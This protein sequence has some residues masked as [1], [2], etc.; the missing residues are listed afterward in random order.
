MLDL[1]TR[2]RIDNAR[3]ILVGKV[4]DPKSQVEQITIALIYKFMDD[5]D[6]EAEELGGRAT[7][8]KG[9]F[10]KYSWSNIFDP[11][12]GG[13]ELIN[14]YGEAITRM[15]QNKNIPQ[16]FRDIFKN[17]FLPYRDPETLKSFLK[18]INDFHYDHSERLG[19]AFEYLLS[20]LG[21][22][23]DAGSLRTPRHIIDFIVKVIAPKKN[24]TI[25]DPACGTAGF[26]ISAYKHIR[27]QNTDK[28][29]GNQLTP[30]D[31]KRLM[32][33]IVGHDISPDM[34]RLS[35][36]NMY[37]HGFQNPKI[38]EYD[39]LTSDERWNE[40]YDIILANPPFMTPKGGIRP[41]KRFSIQAN[42]S[43]VL[44]V[45]YI[46]EHIAT[47]GRAGVIVPEGIIFQSAN[48]Y[49]ALRKAL[50]ENG[51]LYAVVSLPAG[52]FNPYS[53]VK[54]SILLMD[55]TLAKKAKDILFVKIEN[56]GFDLGAQRRE[57]DRSDLTEALRIIQAYQDCVRK[58]KDFNV[59]VSD[60]G[61][62]PCACPDLMAGQ[63]QKGNH[64]GIAPTGKKISKAGE[65]TG[66]PL[67]K[68]FHIVPK[69]KIAESGDYNL[70]GD[71]YRERII[72]SHKDWPMVELAKICK[73]QYGYTATAQESGDF[74][75]IRITDIDN[76]GSLT[77]NGQKF[78]TAFSEANQYVLRKGDLL[79]ART[80][81]TFGKT[82]LFR[83][84]FPSVFASYLIRLNFEQ[85][86]IIPA[87]YWYLTKTGNYWQQARALVS[88]GG[89]PQFN[90]NVIVKI[91]IPLPPLSVQK[92]IVAEVEGYQKIIDGARQ[93]I[94]NYKPTIKT[95]PEWP[96][97]L[98]SKAPFEIIDG[99]RG[100]NY[101]QKEDFSNSGY[102]LFLNTKN[103][104]ENGFCFD[105]LSFI[106]KVK[107]AALRKG[108]VMPRDV[109]LTTRGTIGNTAVFDG[110]VPFNAIRINSGMLVF[111]PNENKLVS[112]YLFH[113]F[114]SKNFKDQVQT[115]LSGSA[116]PQLPIRNLLLV[117]IPLPPLKIQK[118]IVAQIEEEQK[119]VEAN[120]KLIEIFEE[121]IKAKIAEV[122][123]EE[124]PSDA[125][126]ELLMVAEEKAEYDNK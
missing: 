9:E 21:V 85:G 109:I 55:R 82:L 17:A 102:C 79:V 28:R 71:R 6:K 22:Q 125:E 66:S 40:T 88:G 106:T 95:D 105:E 87:Y 93:V 75:L 78:V 59:V 96:M 38:Y 62:G 84:D 42:R 116:Q 1:E 122:W 92:E 115:I 24:E 120:K 2:K 8:F 90:A 74:R 41:H 112:E 39:T 113:F 16:L 108:K 91:K 86:K 63:Q 77:S 126:P 104:R 14:L 4:P 34:V 60:V 5:M 36:V 48:A 19:D 80:G 46:M 89:Q 49:K 37:L 81:A 52:V 13:Y 3:D 97:V 72:H 69:T 43:E 83:E 18:E 65:H 20:V 73:P 61:A 123:G 32:N 29:K 101:P 117:N 64:R 10:A 114:Q 110:N 58:G 68:L 30:D 119:L 12:L 121:K 70:T 33:S 57:I 103:V 35:L 25:L 44:F 11:K 45:D 15:N 50:V 27:D 111:R 51:Y 67:K 47:D 53:G 76:D 54:T 26:L 99:D 23:G 31:R 124:A 118:Q 107:D 7:F 94:A 100:I 98:F 56:D